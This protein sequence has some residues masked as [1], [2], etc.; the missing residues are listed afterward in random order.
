[1]GRRFIGFWAGF[2]M[3]TGIGY[4]HKEIL[5][6]FQSDHF[7]NHTMFSVVRFLRSPSS[8]DQ[9]GFG[10]AS[11]LSSSHVTIKTETSQKCWISKVAN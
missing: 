11:L 4:T 6:N 8:H 3:G 10:V 1:M 9:E 5:L 7:V 2:C